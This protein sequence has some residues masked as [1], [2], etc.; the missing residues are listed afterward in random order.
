MQ[1]AGAGRDHF[2][3]INSQEEV[4]LQL[5]VGVCVTVHR[6]IGDT[7]SG[8]HLIVGQELTRSATWPR[9]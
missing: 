3:H 2:Q 6:Q 7:D 4:K 5:L 8:K 1:A 9:R